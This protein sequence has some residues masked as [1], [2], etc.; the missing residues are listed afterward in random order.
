MILLLVLHQ[1]DAPAPPL[2]LRMPLMVLFAAAAA[3]AAA[4]PAIQ[5]GFWLDPRP[6]SG[7]LLDMCWLP[8]SLTSLDLNGI[9]LA[10]RGCREFGPDAAASYAALLMK[11][12]EYTHLT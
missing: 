7:P 5:G 10:C 1:A 11:V 2:L 4:V 9:S 12:C 8:P 3:V 6:G